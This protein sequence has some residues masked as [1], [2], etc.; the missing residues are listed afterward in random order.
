MSSFDTFMLGKASVLKGNSFICSLYYSV[1]SCKWPP[2]LTECGRLRGLNHDKIS[3]YY[4]LFSKLCP[5]TN[6][7]TSVCIYTQ[8][9]PH[10]NPHACSS[11]KINVFN[12]LTWCSKEFSEWQCQ[13][14]QKK[15]SKEKN[16]MYSSVTQGNSCCSQIDMV[17]GINLRE[18]EFK[19]VLTGD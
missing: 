10:K 5:H 13:T 19:C 15:S 3:S 8:K 18:H 2:K 7:H 11:H 16:E 14:E 9:N 12:L 6:P 4:L 1:T 17:N